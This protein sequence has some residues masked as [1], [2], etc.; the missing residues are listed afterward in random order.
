MF[1]LLLRALTIFLGVMSCM[2][3]ASRG[4]DFS[5]S[6]FLEGLLDGYDKALLFLIGWAADLARDGLNAMSEYFDWRWNLVLHP[7]WRHIYILLQL[8]FLKD[9]LNFA[10]IGLV[11][12]KQASRYGGILIALV[13]AFCAG[14][15]DPGTGA[16]KNNLLIG[17]I[18]IGGFFAYALMMA[19]VTALFH[20]PAFQ[21]VTGKAETFWEFVGNRV[22]MAAVRA[23][24]GFL[25]LAIGLPFV[26]GPGAAV[27]MLAALWLAL[28]AEWLRR[29]W[30]QARN[31][32]SD[33]MTW[34]AALPAAG[35]IQLGLDMI[36]TVSLAVV[37]IAIDHALT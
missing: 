29:G 7:H 25:I 34:R 20:R 6:P 12:A 33:G 24:C 18:A 14:L 23:F 31:L 2:N 36:A 28:A 1:K 13:A 11:Q 37:V 17:A 26:S 22:G 21:K 19:F 3:L 35:N 10:E 5:L 8:Y 16:Y 15:V 27:V 32:V 9:S 30:K 4:F